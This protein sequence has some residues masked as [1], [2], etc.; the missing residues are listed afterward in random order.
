MKMNETTLRKII[1]EEIEKLDEVDPQMASQIASGFS[2]NTEALNFLLSLVGMAGAAWVAK[3]A[4]KS[5]IDML[6]GSGSKVTDKKISESIKKS[7]MKEN[8]VD[9]ATAQLILQAVA[10]MATAGVGAT[11]L[12][13]YLADAA[14]KLG[15]KP[16]TGPDAESKFFGEKLK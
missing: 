10:A 14:K 7:L 12:S 6:K 3:P 1:R 5:A 2:T 15:V 11:V 13:D 9:P 16:G 4:I 8:V